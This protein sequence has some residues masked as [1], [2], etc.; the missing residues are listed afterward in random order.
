M[1]ES[2]DK[3]LEGH[4]LKAMGEFNQRVAADPNLA[5]HLAGK[6]RLVRLDLGGGLLYHFR[7]VDNQLT[8]LQRGDATGSQT[9]TVLSDSRT[10]TALLTRELKPIKAYATGK[11]KIKG[12]LGDL[13]MLKKI[14]ES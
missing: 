8:A 11:L 14:F 6:E 2:A 5:D 4:L 10:L 7:L 9:I 1:P 3:D 13:L 12:D